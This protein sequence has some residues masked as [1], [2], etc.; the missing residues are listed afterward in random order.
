MVSK[1]LERAKSLHDAI[2]DILI[3]QWDPIGVWGIP[4]AQDEYNSYVPQIYRL[5]VSRKPLHEV[6]EYLWWLE[7]EH[8]GL[9]GDRQQT[10]QIAETLFKL[11]QE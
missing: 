7:T 2:H 11:T 8:M 1:R 6:F 10:E 9:R 5:L 3:E 4:E